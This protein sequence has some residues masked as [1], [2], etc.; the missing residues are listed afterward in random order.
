MNTTALREFLC[1]LQSIEYSLPG[2]PFNLSVKY[3]SWAEEI[4]GWPLPSGDYIAE[5]SLRDPGFGQGPVKLA[6]IEFLHIHSSPRRGSNTNEY[7]EK[8]FSLV[9]LSKNLKEVSSNADGV[10]FE[11]S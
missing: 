7:Q 10:H 8:L 1:H 2:D 9:L 6:E 11:N 4:V 3:R 5:S